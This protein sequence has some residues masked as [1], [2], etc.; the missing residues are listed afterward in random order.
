MQSLSLKETLRWK[1]QTIFLTTGSNDRGYFLRITEWHAKGANRVVFFPAGEHFYGWISLCDLL[2]QMGWLDQ[3]DNADSKEYQVDVE[4]RPTLVWVPPE[5]N[6]NKVV[7]DVWGVKVQWDSVVVALTGVFRKESTHRFVVKAMNFP[8]NR[9]LV[10][11]NSSEESKLILDTGTVWIGNGVLSFQ[12][13][14]LETSK[15]HSSALRGNRWIKVWGLPVMAWTNKIFNKIGEYCGCLA[16]VNSKTKNKDF[17][18]FARLK[19]KPENLNSIPRHM[20]VSWLNASCDILI[21]VETISLL[22]VFISA[23]KST[24]VM[25]LAARLG[26]TLVDSRI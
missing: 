12:P 2:R 13:W 25:L 7:V 1:G 3:Q 4:N 10:L 5:P 8:T 16:V 19:I 17:L 26:M 21:D 6:G 22:M 15:I 9:A 23:L 14:T 24:L 20:E 11:T 18:P